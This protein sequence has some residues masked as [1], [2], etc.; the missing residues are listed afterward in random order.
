[1]LASDEL[2]Q[3]I[4]ENAASL[5]LNIVSTEDKAVFTTG[6]MQKSFSMD[7]S[8]NHMWDEHV[9]KLFRS[10]GFPVSTLS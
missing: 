3:E 4:H 6:T 9:E 10:M 7:K 5:S 1:L 8:M 2:A